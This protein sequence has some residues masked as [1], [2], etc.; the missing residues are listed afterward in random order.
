MARLQ[1]TFDINASQ[2]EHI[3][4]SSAGGHADTARVT[5]RHL[6]GPPWKKNCPSAAKLPP[7][8]PPSHTHAHTGIHCALSQNLRRHPPACPSFHDHN[9][10]HGAAAAAD[11]GTTFIWMPG[12]VSAQNKRGVAVVCFSK[13]DLQSSLRPNRQARRTASLAGCG[14]HGHGSTVRLCFQGSRGGPQMNFLTRHQ[15]D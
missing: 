3:E 14:C 1:R 10:K 7:T 15:V 8:P 9:S 2:R 11:D 13:R 4:A 12:N 5:E 6:T